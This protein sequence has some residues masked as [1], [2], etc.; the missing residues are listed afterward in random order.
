MHPSLPPP[1][2]PPPP[3]LAIKTN[4]VTPPKHPALP[5]SG[6]PGSCL[7]SLLIYNGHPFKDHWAYF[8]RSQKNPE[9]GVKIHATGSV[10]TEFVFEVKRNHDL[11]NTED[12]PTKI[13]PLAWV[14]GIYFDEDEGRMLG[15]DNGDEELID[16]EPICGFE[17]ALYKV[18]VP[19]KSLVGVEETK[20]EGVARRR[21]VQRDCQTWIVESAEQLAQDGIFSGDVAGF[22]RAIQQ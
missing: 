17:R 2:P 3:A 8:V 5:P 20:R 7:V 11:R 21:V 4:T 22:L 13:V 14:D 18:E 15:K 6:P 16:H 12:I 9:L 19:G 10:S 1:P